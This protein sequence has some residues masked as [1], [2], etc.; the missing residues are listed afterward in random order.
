MLGFVEEIVLLQL[1]ERS[2]RPLELP[3]AAGDIVVAGAAL[4]ELAL[5]NRID[6]D[7]EQLLLVD[8]SA[9]GD[10]ILDKVLSSLAE[11]SNLTAAGALEIAARDARAHQAAALRRLVEKGILREDSGRL[12]WVFRT[13][14]YQIIDDREEEE[15]KTRLRRVLLSDEL[16]DPRDI[17]LICLIDACG[18]IGLVLSPD[19]AD[20]CR[21]RIADLGRLDLIG[22]AVAKAVGE[23]RL[24]VRYAGG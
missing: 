6:T 15:V 18:L 13:R 16:P 20:R 7:L 14:K 11:A 19:E 22:Q 21:Q 2:G 3:A 5:Q 12:L 24:V 8:S 9:T 17:V 1:D 10:D 4:M 23:I